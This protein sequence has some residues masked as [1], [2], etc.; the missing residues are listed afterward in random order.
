V[1]PAMNFGIHEEG[2]TLLKKMVEDIGGVKMWTLWVIAAIMGKRK[3]ETV[4]VKGRKVD[5][6]KISTLPPYLLSVII[7]LTDG[8]VS[9]MRKVLSQAELY[10][11]VGVY[12]LYAMYSQMKDHF[13]DELAFQVLRNLSR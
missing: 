1:V 9:D 13:I 11:S 5:V 10:A 6:G 12:D 8:D 7:S 3:G 2:H 4:P